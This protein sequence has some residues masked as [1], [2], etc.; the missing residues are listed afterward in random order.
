MKSFFC[1]ISFTSLQ[2]NIVATI[3]KANWT[4]QVQS[5]RSALHSKIH[6]V[7]IN[8]PR[9]LIRS[10]RFTSWSM[11]TFICLVFN[12]TTS[13][14]ALTSR[15]DRAPCGDA[16]SQSVPFYYYIGDTFTFNV[17]STRYKIM[18]S[19]IL[20]NQNNVNVTVQGQ[21]HVNGCFGTWRADQTRWPSVWEMSALKEW[22][23]YKH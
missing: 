6:Q 8:L 23:I 20:H 1:N 7:F 16:N 4:A 11:T 3:L 18:R 2:S 5:S 9:T 13:C 19:A 17:T 10:G 14:L 12:R 21:L 15:A 22:L